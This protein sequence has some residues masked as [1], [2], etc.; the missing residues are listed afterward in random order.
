[1]PQ[2]T[3]EIH[4]ILT[5]YVKANNLLATSPTFKRTTVASNRTVRSRYRVPL[6]IHADMA[7]KEDSARKPMDVSQVSEVQHEE[8]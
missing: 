1:M 8:G 7:P 6:G 2:Q 3:T 4:A 5:G